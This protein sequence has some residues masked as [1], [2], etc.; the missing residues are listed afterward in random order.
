MGLPI[1][2]DSWNGVQQ[3]IIYTGRSSSDS[4]DPSDW[5]ELRR[6]SVQSTPSYQDLLPPTPTFTRRIRP[7]R[8]QDSIWAPNQSTENQQRTGRAFETSPSPATTT[9]VRP[10]F[11]YDAIPTS[12]ASRLTTSS[13]LQLNESFSAFGEI[14]EQ[15]SLEERGPRP[16]STLIPRFL[17]PSFGTGTR[18]RRTSSLTNS[19]E[20]WDSHTSYGGA[21][22]TRWLSRLRGRRCV[23]RRS[24]SGSLRTSTQET[25]TR[26]PSPLRC[27]PC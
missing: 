15:A 18:D 13:Q 25:G 22:V 2:V 10:T 1:Y 21:T 14:Q 3:Q 4:L 9:N 23:S 26:T 7:S 12:N 8:V 17:R 24:E 6:S 5:P 11:T 19:A 27:W 16:V 20:R